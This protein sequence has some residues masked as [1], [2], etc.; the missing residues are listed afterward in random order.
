MQENETFLREL[1]LSLL[2]IVGTILVNLLHSELV[3][4]V[5][6]VF[7]TGA[8]FWIVLDIRVVKEGKRWQCF[9]SY[10]SLYVYWWLWLTVH[11]IFQTVPYPNPNVLMWIVVGLWVVILFVQYLWTRSRFMV[12]F[13]GLVVLLL[14]VQFFSPITGNPFV[15]MIRIEVYFF[16][17][18]VLSL[19]SINEGRTC[20][21]E[22]GG[23][24]NQKERRDNNKN[25]EENVSM[26]V[27]AMLLIYYGWILMTPV[28]SWIAYAIVE[29]LLYLVYLWLYT[30]KFKG[31]DTVN[32]EYRNE[33]IHVY[34]RHHFTSNVKGFGNSE[35]KVSHGCIRHYDDPEKQP[36]KQRKLLIPDYTEVKGDYKKNFNKGGGGAPIVL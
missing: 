14:P 20:D 24:Y 11:M 8:V 22:E 32:Y 6:I 15:V 3:A 21:P 23:M 31:R 9:V 12:L 19:I 10:T 28:L 5:F 25:R 33:E 35:N 4:I 26:Y 18:H 34:Q 36:Q 16:R 7:G 2:A 29:F 1:A 30:G 27:E 17:Y 13:L